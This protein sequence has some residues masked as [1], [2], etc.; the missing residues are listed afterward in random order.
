MSG[1]DG[2]AL[3]EAAGE[4]AFARDRRI[5]SAGRDERY[6]TLFRLVSIDLDLDYVVQ[7]AAAVRSMHNGILTSCNVEG[8]EPTRSPRH[9]FQRPAL[10]IERFPSTS[11]SCSIYRLIAC[12]RGLALDRH[13]HPLDSLRQDNA[14]PLAHLRDS[15][16]MSARRWLGQGHV[17]EA[18]GQLRHKALDTAA[19]AALKRLSNDVSFYNGDVVNYVYGRIT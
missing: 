10:W 16:S 8:L 3:K 12:Q 7:A 2:R 11:R 5:R 14:R 4:E 1:G 6:E 9:S 18:Q 13:C 19:S 17:G 15:R